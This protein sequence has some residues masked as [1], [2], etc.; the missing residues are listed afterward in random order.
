[1]KRQKRGSKKLME[2]AAFDELD[3]DDDDD[4]EGV[5]IPLRD[6]KE[7]FEKKPA[8]FGEGKEYDT[9]LEDKL[10]EELEQSRKAQIVNINNLKNNPSLGTSNKDKEATKG[11]LLNLVPLYSVFCFF[12]L[13]FYVIC[14]FCIGKNL[15]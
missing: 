14:L 15:C 2:L 3:Y 5:D 13:D 6:M 11:L 9:S 10:V 8:G 7:W 1:M 12:I 4:E